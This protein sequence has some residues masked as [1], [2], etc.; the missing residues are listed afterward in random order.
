MLAMAREQPDR[1]AVTLDQLEMQ[2]RPNAGLATSGPATGPASRRVR[3]L[4]LNGQQMIDYLRSGHHSWVQALPPHTVI[5][6]DQTHPGHGWGWVVTLEAP[7]FSPVPEGQPIP[8]WRPE[9]C[10]G[11]K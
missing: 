1:F 9:N 4:H 8:E 10:L 3:K 2:A 7:T 11:W 5:K 6:W